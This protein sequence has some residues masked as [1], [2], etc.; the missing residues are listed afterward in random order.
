MSGALEGLGVVEMVVEG[1]IHQTPFHGESI[2]TFL[3]TCPN[4]H[5][6]RIMA[7]PPPALAPGWEN[8]IWTASHIRKYTHTGMHARKTQTH[9]ITHSFTLS[10]SL[11]LCSGSC[12]S[13]FNDSRCSKPFC[14]QIYFILFYS[15]LIVSIIMFYLIY[16]FMCNTFYFFIS[17]NEQWVRYEYCKQC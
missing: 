3:H 12:L 1:G 5:V 2:I 6:A 15:L 14:P 13:C 4:V 10:L 9:T 8:S 11:S 17:I 16:L 7:K